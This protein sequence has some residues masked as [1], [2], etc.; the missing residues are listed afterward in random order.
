M[1]ATLSLRARY[2]IWIVLILTG[3]VTSIL[4]VVQRREVRMI[5]EE[6][7]NRGVLTARFIANLNLRAMLL[8]DIET[9]QSNVEEQIDD[10][11]VYIVFYDRFGR[12][13][14]GSRDIQGDRDI[15]ENS[16]LSP[17][18]G[19]DAMHVE[20][21]WFHVPD[22]SL[23]VLEIEIPIFAPESATRWGSVKTGHLLEDMHREVRSVSRILVG[24]GLAGLAVGL[25]ASFLLGRRITRPIRNLVDGTQKIARGDFST[26]IESD[27]RDE[28][29]ELARSF[30]DMTRD[31][32][33]MRERMAEANRKLVQAEKLASIGRLAA[34]IAHEIRNPL[35]SV[36]LN[37]QKVS[38]SENLDEVEKEHIALCRDGIDQIEKFIREM[39][40]FTR[41]A[42][43][44]CD[45]FA[46]PQ[47]L[48]SSRKILEGV[49]QKKN[50]RLDV[51]AASD[52][53]PVFVDADKIRQVLLNV[54]RNACEAVE[55]GGKVAVAMDTA[56]SSGRPMV[57]IRISD[58]GSGI[59]EKDWENIFEPFFTT[60]ASGVGLGLAHARKIVA[61]HGGTIRVLKK[62]GKGSLFEIRL[63]CEEGR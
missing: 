52:L 36:N 15:F 17:D 18:A 25:L 54:L 3:L 27:S 39:L 59:P 49:F 7:K 50:V 43:L 60:K 10:N 51:K 58:N 2:T 28:I 48:E 24:L 42:D 8:W 26:T 23:R 40:D 22:R 38:G 45:L 13:L 9:L 20:G 46:V 63:P 32:V 57:R 21:G 37:I 19:P 6:T 5:T 41:S 61:Q 55:P 30:N 4:F 14:A 33:D 62:Q 56:A 12:P 31:L 44:N 34:T 47:I 11:L 1:R 29:G 53:P 35:T 16:R